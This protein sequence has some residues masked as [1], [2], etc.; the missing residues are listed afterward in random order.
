MPRQMQLKLIAKQTRD[1][2]SKILLKMFTAKCTVTGTFTGHLL[3]MQLRIT[4][5]SKKDLSG[6]I[7]LWRKTNHTGMKVVYEVYID[8][9]VIGMSYIGDA[10]VAEGQLFTGDDYSYGIYM[11]KFTAEVKYGFTASTW[12]IFVMSSSTIKALLHI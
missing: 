7:R 4:V 6:D 12:W 1:V 10:F 11:Y 8:Y 9:S 3:M 2:P 5:N